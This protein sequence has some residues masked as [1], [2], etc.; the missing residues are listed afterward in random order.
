MKILAFSDLHLVEELAVDLVTASVGADLVIGAG[1]FCNTRQGLP[2]AMEM[3]AG[4]AAPMV[5]VPG[6]R[7]SVV[8]VGPSEVVV[9]TNY[10]T[11]P[12]FSCR[13]N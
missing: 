2:R 3:L 9:S 4:I 6:R 11:V 7:R 8:M 1:D 12:P 13:Y 5:V 10:A